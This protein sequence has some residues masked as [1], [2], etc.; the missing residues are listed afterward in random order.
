MA[1]DEGDPHGQALLTRG[2]AS[3]GDEIAITGSL[4]CAAGRLRMLAEGL[5]FESRLADH[6]KEAHNHPAPRVSQGITLA[7][8]RIVTAIDVSDGLVDDLGK[9]CKAS[10]VEAVIRADQVPADDFLK[11]AFPDE[12]LAL[13]LSGGE[14][15][16]LLFTA[17]PQ[18]LDGVAPILDVPVSVI[19][20]IV[21]GTPK[22]RV[23]DRE[24]NDMPVESGGWDHF[25]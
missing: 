21:A 14:D 16:E 24:G 10:D 2:S 23:L 17:P 15:Y 4:G 8:R 20:D 25:A 18:I 12:W 13:A 7:R 3:P 1:I 6:L 9:L 19:G 5:S 11:R 22:V